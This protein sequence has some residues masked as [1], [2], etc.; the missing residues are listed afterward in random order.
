MTES[1]NFIRFSV[2]LPEDLLKEFDKVTEMLGIQGRSDAIRKAMR[3]F[4]VNYTWMH[5]TAGS[6][7][8][9]ITIILDHEV[10]G[11][12]DEITELEHKNINLIMS[13]MHVHLDE[14]E[15]MIVL[16]VR[17]NAKD[18]EKLNN[19]LLALKGVK[20]VKYTIMTPGAQLP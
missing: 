6:R 14:R 7:V 16:A 8:G 4:I 9:S 2:S 5:S 15:C 1:E 19:Q 11:I 17:G 10:T 3:D 13:S 20:L 18:I 12:M